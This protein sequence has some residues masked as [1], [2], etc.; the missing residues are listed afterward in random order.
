M[1]KIS[2]TSTELRR[3][4]LL[5]FARTAA[6]VLVAQMSGLAAPG[7][8]AMTESEAGARAVISETVDEVLAVLRDKS[9]PTEQR[10]RSLEQIVYG[11]FDLYVMSRLVLARNW[12]RFSEEQKAEYV[13]EFKQYL[14]NSYGSRIERYDQQEVEII[15]E[16]EEPRGDVVIQTKILGGEFDGAL[17]DYRLRKQEAGWR[18]I[19]VVI[20]GISM[21][22]NYRDQFKSIV[23]TGGPELLLQKLKEKNAAGMVIDKTS[24]K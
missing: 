3:R 23:S 12:K 10:I 18:V 1:M 4:G 20:E 15:G 2:T 22:S 21:V 16:R 24:A 11:R 19:D 13:E 7:A 17:I 6:L 14:T 8:G 5:R 9:V